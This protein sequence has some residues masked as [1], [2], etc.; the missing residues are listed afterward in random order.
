MPIDPALRSVLRPF[1]RRALLVSFVKAIS[2]ASLVVA[3]TAEIGALFD[4]RNALALILLIA[5]ATAAGAV[6]AVVGRPSPLMLARRIDAGAHLND[7][8]VTAIGCDGDGMPAAVRRACLAALAAESP[9]RV[10][11]FEAPPHW[12]RWIAAAGAVQLI[13]VPMLF[14][15][16]AARAT[17]P[18][19]SALA[20]PAASTSA[21][22]NG[23]NGS[24]DAKSNPPAPGTPANAT[25]NPTPAVAPAGSAR[26]SDAVTAN[27][28]D[29]GGN[30]SDA[31]LRLAIA[32]ADAD[33]AAGRVPLARRAIV[34]RYFAA[35]QSQRRPPR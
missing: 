16:P 18:G 7:L 5:I 3:L 14:R 27:A 32:N 8:V 11:P 31:R 22:A 21:G 30:G 34:Q 1:E 15:A 6:Y 29:A 10:M 28:R 9:K 24:Q 19:L 23:K 4:V 2:I 25:V 33:I 12:R 13:A 26:G 17:A 35:I 20:M